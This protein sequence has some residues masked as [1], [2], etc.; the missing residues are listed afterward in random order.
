MFCQCLK[1]SPVQNTIFKRTR[2]S[3]MPTMKFHSINSIELKVK[4][5]IM[6]HHLSYGAKLYIFLYTKSNFRRVIA[7][8]SILHWMYQIYGNVIEWAIW[9]TWTDSNYY[10]LLWNKN[11]FIRMCWKRRVVFFCKL[12][13]LSKNKCGLFLSNRRTIVR[14]GLGSTYASYLYLGNKTGNG[15]FFA[16]LLFLR[17]ISLIWNHKENLFYFFIIWTLLKNTQNI[18]D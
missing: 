8:L 7:M 1:S 10:K 6:S 4:R 13:N 15:C 14:C 11:L 16:S 12:N 18:R 17:I 9:N 5:L 3:L 2:R